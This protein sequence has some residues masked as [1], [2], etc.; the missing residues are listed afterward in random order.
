[1][2]EGNC[3]TLAYNPAEKAV[4]YFQIRPIRLIDYNKRTGHK[5]RLKDMYD[6]KT[7][8]EVFLFY[9]DQIGYQDPQKIARSWNGSGWKTEIY[10]KK[11][12]VYL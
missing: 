2:V 3:D 8:K 7:S 1:M 11:V 5:Y 12:K 10:W 4:G 9:A 6:Y